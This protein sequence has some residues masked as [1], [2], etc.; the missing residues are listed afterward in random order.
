MESFTLRVKNIFARHRD[1]SEQS[2]FNM[3]EIVIGVGIILILSVGGILTYNGITQ[4]AKSSSVEEAAS[5]VFTA[6]TAYELDADN[7]TNFSTAEKEYMDSQG[8]KKKIIVTVTKNS[9]IA[10]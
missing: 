8:A 4:K 5:Q 3:L 7:N 9:A 1:S 2:G 6:A 10:P